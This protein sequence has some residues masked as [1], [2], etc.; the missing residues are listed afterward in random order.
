MN[1]DLV[2]NEAK[3]FGKTCAVAG[4]PDVSAAALENQSL[5]LDHFIL[6]CYESLSAYDGRRDFAR[7]AQETE[8]AK[9]RGFLEECSTQALK[10]CLRSE[11]LSNLQR[12]RLL[13]VLLWAGELSEC[14]GASAARMGLSSTFEQRPLEQRDADAT[15]SSEIPTGS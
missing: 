13:D 8:R 10:V 15:A 1:A 3:V 6:R 14:L 5:C 2:G 11:Q 4:C 9:L 12:S 7:R